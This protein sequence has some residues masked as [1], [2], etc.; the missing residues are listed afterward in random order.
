MIF[1]CKVVFDPL[2]ETPLDIRA[3]AGPTATG[4][5]ASYGILLFAFCTETVGYDQLSLRDSK[6]MDGKGAR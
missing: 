2:Q 6:C 5:R 1:L 3:M 4:I